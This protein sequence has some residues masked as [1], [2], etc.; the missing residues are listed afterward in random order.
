MDRVLEVG[1]YA[2]GYC[3]RLF[4]QSGHD[5]VQVVSARKDPAWVSQAS[6]DAYLHG[7]K[8]RIA[9]SDVGLIAELAS[10]CDVA[11]L[12]A[13]SADEIDAS[14]FIDWSSKV[15]VAITP[16]GRTGPKRNWCA[17][18][19]TLLAMGG[20]TNLMGDPE[21]APLTLPGHFVDF[22]SGGFAYSAAMAARYA[23]SSAA[24]DVA[25]LEVIMALSQFTTVMW[26]CA[27]V[28]RS[29]HAND[30]WTVVPTNL[31]RCVDGWVYMNIVPHFWDPFTTFL[32]RPELL[33]DERFETNAGRMKHRDALHLIIADILGKWTR[34]EILRKAEE[35]RIPLGVVLSFREVLEDEHLR[36][37][38]LWQQV[39]GP[40]R[41]SVTS[42][43][44]A[45]KIHGAQQADTT[46]R[47]IEDLAH[48]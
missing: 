2:S 20:Y 26:T 22:Q 35:C 30:F 8:R 14:G 42:P 21:R 28:V 6:M 47:N 18:S 33:L 29:R 9:T 25:K 4:A 1:S 11:I 27:R 39:S 23:E 5:V 44:V 46:L 32:D 13:A 40:S 41:R 34:A 31:F 16:F 45:W 38:Q 36:E 10:R 15:K 12:E 43:R 48:G 37:R 24:I 3:G 17:T 19:S 7:N